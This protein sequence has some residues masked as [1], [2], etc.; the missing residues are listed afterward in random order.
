LRRILAKRD[1]GCIRQA[2]RASG[3]PENAGVPS[4]RFMES[5]IMPNWFGAMGLPMSRESIV[6][7]FEFIRD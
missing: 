1:G 7:M 2:F 4:R 6:F 3:R 5:K